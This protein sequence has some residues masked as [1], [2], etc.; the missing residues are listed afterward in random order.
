MSLLL[1]GVAEVGGVRVIGVNLMGKLGKK[2]RA[3]GLGNGVR[4]L[5]YEI[6]LV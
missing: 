5:A 2:M 3:T 1:E 4:Q 6:I